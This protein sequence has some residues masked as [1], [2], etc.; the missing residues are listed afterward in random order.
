MAEPSNVSSNG[1]SEE[2]N[3]IVSVYDDSSWFYKTFLSSFDEFILEDCNRGD[4]F[5]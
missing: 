1:K 5:E 3:L 4:I 2:S